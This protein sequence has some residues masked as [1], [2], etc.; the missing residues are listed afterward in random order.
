MKVERRYKVSSDWSLEKVVG[1]AVVETADL[2]DTRTG[3]VYREGAYRVRFP[4]KVEGFRA[5]TFYGE[6]AWS[7]AERLARDALFAERRKAW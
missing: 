5:K 3:H 4:R 1:P 6:T 2:T 7:D